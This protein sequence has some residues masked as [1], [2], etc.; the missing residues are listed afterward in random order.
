[1]KTLINVVSFPDGKLMWCSNH[2]GL[3]AYA[4]CC[5]SLL[6]S[7][8]SGAN[9]LALVSLSRRFVGLE[10]ATVILSKSRLV[11][12]FSLLNKLK[13]VHAVWH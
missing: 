10:I 6:T 3:G 4:L 9:N 12:L 1:M 13:D 7:V 8:F 2:I 5:I 11:F